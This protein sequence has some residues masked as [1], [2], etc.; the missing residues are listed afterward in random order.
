[1]YHHLFPYADPRHPLQICRPGPFFQAREKSAIRIILC[2]VILKGLQF[3]DSVVRTLEQYRRAV[4]KQKGKTLFNFIPQYLNLPPISFKLEKKGVQLEN[5]LSPLVS[6]V[7][8]SPLWLADPYRM[9][10]Q[11]SWRYSDAIFGVSFP[12]K[13]V[14]QQQ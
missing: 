8:W 2:F 4:E 7:L 5:Y 13:K 10:Q 14:Q 11:R 1:M 3:V 9:D 12:L 6:Q